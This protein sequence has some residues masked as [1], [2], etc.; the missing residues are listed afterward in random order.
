MRKSL[1]ATLSLV[2]LLFLG[3]CLIAAEVIAPS[4]V[5]THAPGEVANRTLAVR[6]D[7]ARQAFSLTDCASGQ[8]FVKNGRLDD[9]GGILREEE[10]ADPV[11]GA[12]WRIAIAR[13]GG[14]E[15]ALELYPDLPF[16]LVRRGGEKR[17]THAS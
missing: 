8:V 16:A 12:G 6:Y 7:S 14:G 3:R 15:I 17:P 2:G 11:F 13:N 5:V 9:A 4:P 10:A 1:I